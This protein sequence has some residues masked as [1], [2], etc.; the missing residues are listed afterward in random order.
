VK[1]VKTV[2]PL[3]KTERAAFPAAG[4]RIELMFAPC[5]HCDATIVVHPAAIEAARL[6]HPES[7]DLSVS[8]DGAGRCLAF[9][10]KR[11]ARRPCRHVVAISLQLLYTP[12]EGSKRRKAA[13]WKAYSQ[14]RHPIAEEVDPAWDLLDRLW[15]L[16]GAGAHVEYPTGNPITEREVLLSWTVHGGDKASQG[17][18]AVT[19]QVLHARNVPRFLEE[20][21]AED[22][23][24]EDDEEVEEDEE[25]D[26][27][28]EDEDLDDET[29][30]FRVELSRI[31]T[32][33]K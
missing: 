5:P 1:T 11:P 26:E 16:I 8:G 10:G 33:V 18:Y 28:E 21:T 9:A 17:S 31:P 22:E 32:W 13:S 29:E 27:E 20:L 30:D 25:W 24:D 12:P 15:D 7:L 2:K 14:W 23:D 3:K 6:A 4:Q 19:G